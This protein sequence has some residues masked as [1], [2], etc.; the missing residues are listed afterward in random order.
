MVSVKL[1][2]WTNVLPSENCKQQD[3]NGPQGTYRCFT[4]FSIKLEEALLLMI[5]STLPIGTFL[6]YQFSP[7]IIFIEIMEK[8]TFG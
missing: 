7:F 8:L 4:C 2:N 5:L 6:L 1:L 3:L